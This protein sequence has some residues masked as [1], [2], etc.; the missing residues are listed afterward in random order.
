MHFLFIFYKLRANFNVM[1]ASIVYCNSADENNFAVNSRGH[2]RRAVRKDARHTKPS[3]GQRG[4][5]EEPISLSIIIIIIRSPTC[6]S[7]SSVVPLLAG[8]IRAHMFV[9]ISALCFNATFINLFHPPPPRNNTYVFECA[10][11][12]ARGI[13]SPSDSAAP[14]EWPSLIPRGIR[15]CILMTSLPSWNLGPTQNNCL[16]HSAR[17]TH[18]N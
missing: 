18:G 7:F 13:N 1:G 11:K 15:Q 8:T 17:P 12:R 6:C 5:S 4:Q 9:S 14:A 10:S 2:L 3:R 16:V